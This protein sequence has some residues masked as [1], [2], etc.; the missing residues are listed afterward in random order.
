MKELGTWV[1]MA[2]ERWGR[3]K[4][5][6]L[7]L[8]RGNTALAMTRRVSADLRVQQA[9]CSTRGNYLLAI[10][11]ILPEVDQTMNCS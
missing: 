2:K 1:E 7:W 11:H 4:E 6:G 8:E 3:V 10:L 5:R 9:T